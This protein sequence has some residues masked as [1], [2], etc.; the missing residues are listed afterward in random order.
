MVCVL[1]V[2]ANYT[3]KR[4][5]P[6]NSEYLEPSGIICD[7]TY[8]CDNCPGTTTGTVCQGIPEGEHEKGCHE[9]GCHEKCCQVLINTLFS[10]AITL[11]L[12]HSITAAIDDFFYYQDLET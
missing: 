11:N 12:M 3:A 1:T 2:S 10:L 4:N 5:E 8:Q 7:V 6:C 9:K